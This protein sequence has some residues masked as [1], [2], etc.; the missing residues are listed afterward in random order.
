MSWEK[1]REREREGETP[2]LRSW[3]K[4]PVLGWAGMLWN[5]QGATQR[6][7]FLITGVPAQPSMVSIESDA[8]G[9]PISLSTGAT[10]GIRKMQRE[11]RQVTRTR[12]GQRWGPRP[13]GWSQEGPGK[14]WPMVWGPWWGRDGEMGPEMDKEWALNAKNPTPHIPCE[15]P[16]PR[17][18]LATHLD[19]SWQDDSQ[20][21]THF[22]APQI[23]PQ[24][25]IAKSPPWSDWT[26][27]G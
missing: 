21:I 27:T 19:L 8:G 6:S 4:C 24:L 16:Q 17:E 2:N 12:E 5:V 3:S 10:D 13:V 23:F 7:C 14:R 1:Q 20:Q 18:S 22:R 11:S 15:K 9:T 26:Q 25:V